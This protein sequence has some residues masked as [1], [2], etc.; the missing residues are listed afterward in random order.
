M[1]WDRPALVAPLLFGLY[2]AVRLLPESREPGP[3]WLIG[4]ALLLLGLLLFVPVLAEL[5]RRA[6]GFGR[7]LGPLA[8]LGLAASVGQ[9]LVDLWVG[10]V[11]EDKAAMRELFQRVQDVPGVLPAFYQV[12]PLLFHLGLVALLVAAARRT[13]WWSPLVAAAGVALSAVS[14]DL[15]PVAAVLWVLALSPLERRPV[16][17]GGAA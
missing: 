17:V 14:L 7:V 1:T 3:S 15:L 4:H 13:A 8:Y 12:G 6:R 10:L 16:A 11:A 2:G 9:V 5:A